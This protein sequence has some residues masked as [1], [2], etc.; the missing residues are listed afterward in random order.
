MII[1]KMLPVLKQLVLHY[2][3]KTYLLT[4]GGVYNE[5]NDQPRMT[6]MYQAMYDQN[7]L[8]K[9]SELVTLASL[10]LSEG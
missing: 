6:A 10:N 5:L 9:E 3:K 2:P 1:K 4:M 8:D 7:L